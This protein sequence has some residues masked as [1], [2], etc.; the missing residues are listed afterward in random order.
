MGRIRTSLSLYS[1]LF[2][3]VLCYCNQL[4]CSWDLFAKSQDPQKYF[5]CAATTWNHLPNISRVVSAK[6]R[7]LQLFFTRLELHRHTLYTVFDFEF[8]ALNWVGSSAYCH[9]TNINFGDC[10]RDVQD[11][12]F[13]E[14][15]SWIHSDSG[16]PRLS[17]IEFESIHFHIHSSTPNA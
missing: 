14:N 2:P 12:L 1:V 6:K 8:Y 3:H 11:I 4:I 17:D 9:K 7:G 13:H 5:D 16:S 15:I 10:F